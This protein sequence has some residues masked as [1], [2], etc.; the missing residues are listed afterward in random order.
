[1]KYRHTLTITASLACLLFA[2][3]ASAI[4]SDQIE[5]KSGGTKQYTLMNCSSTA[6]TPKITMY[7]MKYLNESEGYMHFQ[8]IEWPDL[9]NL[10]ID[11]SHYGYF[12]T[13]DAFQ[14]LR[15][16]GGVWE[17][18]E[19][20]NY[21]GYCQTFS[22]PGEFNADVLGDQLSGKISSLRPLKCGPGG[23][24]T[25]VMETEA[26]RKP[27]PEGDHFTRQTAEC[28]TTGE[29]GIIA[30]NGR[31]KLLWAQG[32]LGIRDNVTNET[33]WRTDTLSKGASLCFDS[34]AN[35]VI[36]DAAG[37]PLWQT[38]SQEVNSTATL[39]LTSECALTVEKGSEVMWSNKTTCN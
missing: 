32:A 38:G 27:D 4:G 39:N 8:N 37:Q 31:V 16:D 26:L 25:I 2:S 12:Q 33:K 1:M 28:L 36:F 18:C 23:T 14:S 19:D 17:V 20:I 6:T 9:T 35:L 15:I 24:G 34:Y 13:N 29:P 10:T 21:N 30:N 5:I 7:K 22:L 11:T 3:S